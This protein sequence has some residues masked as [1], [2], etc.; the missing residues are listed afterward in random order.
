[1]LCTIY[2]LIKSLDRESNPRPLA[3][4]NPPALSDN[5][6]NHRAKS[7]HV[8]LNVLFRL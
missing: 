2:H 1:M 5:D 6:A 3:Y 7:P 4:G 8:D